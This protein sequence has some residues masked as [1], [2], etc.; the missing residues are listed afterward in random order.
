MDMKT[1]KGKPRKLTSGLNAE[2]YSPQKMIK[3]CLISIIYPLK[4]V[5]LKQNKLICKANSM[6]CSQ[7]LKLE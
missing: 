4:I 5:G 6:T 3:Y 7:I 1:I 2:K